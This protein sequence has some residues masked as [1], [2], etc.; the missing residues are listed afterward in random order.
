MI[1]SKECYMS[2]GSLER[3]LASRLPT[4]KTTYITAHD[5]GGAR[6]R[7]T[8]HPLD[9]CAATHP[10]LVVHASGPLGWTLATYFPH[11]ETSRRLLG[12]SR[13]RGR[14]PLFPLDIDSRH[15][16]GSGRAKDNQHSWVRLGS[17]GRSPRRPVFGVWSGRNPLS[18]E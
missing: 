9:V 5:G 4:I 1:L 14:A 17:T 13:R 2:V 7:D 6:V 11:E 18:E 15:G 16:A 3:L 10:S 12:G 8:A